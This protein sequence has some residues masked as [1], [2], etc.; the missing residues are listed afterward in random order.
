MK[1]KL[2]IHGM[3]KDIKANNK[4]NVLLNSFGFSISWRP[5]EMGASLIFIATELQRFGITLEK[6][7]CLFQLPSLSK[8]GPE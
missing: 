7:S 5:A 1:R 4:K 8:S 3:H 2:N 6:F